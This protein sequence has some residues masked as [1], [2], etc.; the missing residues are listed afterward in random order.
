MTIGGQVDL[1]ATLA[2]ASMSAESNQ[3]YACLTP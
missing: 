1:L 3:Y 2:A